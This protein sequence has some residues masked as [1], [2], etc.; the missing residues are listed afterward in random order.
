MNQK[1]YS[2][3]WLLADAV[4]LGLVV[5][6]AIILILQPETKAAPPPAHLSSFPA[7]PWLQSP[8]DLQISKDGP[9]HVTVLDTLT[10]TI[11]ITN[12]AGQTLQNVVI[13]DTYTTKVFPAQGNI[14]PYLALYNGNYVA[15]GI[16]VQ[17]FTYTVDT[18]LQRGA[19]YWYLAN[20]AP[21][22]SG[23]IVFTMGI[24]SSLQPR[25]RDPAMGPSDLE[26]S[27]AITT[28]TS[29]VPVDTNPYDN[30]VVSS[31]VGPVLKLEKSLQTETG[32]TNEERIGRLVTYTIRV[33]NLSTSVREDSWP[34][35][36]L[37]VAEQLPA[38]LDFI[39]TWAAVSGVTMEY[40]PTLR[41]IT[42]TYPPDF[43]L[44]PGDVT[45]VT[46]TTR[47]SLTAPT[48]QTIKNDKS[49]CWAISAEMSSPVQ[50]INDLNLKVLSPQDKSAETASPPTAVDQS[51]PNRPV[52]YTVYL[53][54]PL[55]TVLTDVTVIDQLPKTFSFQQMINGPQPTS[56]L[57]NIVRWE[58][59]TI[60][61]NEVISFTF[62]VWIDA[63]TPVEDNCNNKDYPN[64]MTVTAPALPVP[65]VNKYM[66][67]VRVIPQLRV[68]KSVFPSNQV[69]GSVVTY[70]IS[71]KNEGDTTIS[72]LILTDTLPTDFRFH[73]MA[74]SPPG[75]PHIVS[76]TPNVIWWDSFPPLAPG[77]QLDFSFRATVDGTPMN[78]YQNEVFGY[79][80]DTSVCHLNKAGV[81]VE[82]P[83]VYEKTASPDSVV[84]GESF[85]YTVRF[86]NISSV[87]SYAIDRFEDNLPSGFLANGMPNYIYPISPSF[88]L[89]PNGSNEWEHSF[90][91]VVRGEGTNTTWC[92]NLAREDKRSV[93]QEREKFGVHTVDPD[94]LWLNRDKMA[95]VY[96]LP[97]VSLM[98]LAQPN[99]VGRSSVLTV[100]L[101]LTNNLRVANA[102]PV[103]V[104]ALTYKLPRGALTF[105]GPV[106]G[107]PNPDISSDSNYDYYTW[108]NLT[109]PAQG[110]QRLDI[111]FRAPL[112]TANYATYA[113]ALPQTLSICI[114]KYR[115]DIQVVNGVELSKEPTPNTIG[116]FGIVE[117][118]IEATNLTGGPVSGLRITDTLPEGFQYIRTTSGPE[119]IS[120]SPLVWEI[121][122][123]GPV[124]SGL[125]RATIKFLARSY[126][127][128]GK[129][130]NW[131]DGVSASTYITRINGYE[132]KVALMVV[133]GIG[134]YK[135]A[136]PTTVVTGQTV[137]YTITLYNG[138]ETNIRNIR[139]TD[140]LPSGFT[141]QGM[142]YGT[143]PIQI[144][145][146]VWTASSLNKGDSL[147]LA[148]RA[149]VG[150]QVP[151]GYYYNRVSGYAEKAVSP[152]DPVLV[153]DTGDTA[154][155]HVRGLP[156]V[157]RGKAVT[158][159]NVMAGEQVTYTLFLYNEGE[160]MH[161]VRLTD[162]LPPSVT[163][164][165][166][167]GSPA[168]VMTSPLVWDN[169]QVEAGTTV[170]LQFLA[171]VDHLAHSGTYYNRLDAVVDGR[172][173]PPLPQL[174]PLEVTEI[175]RLDVRVSIDDGRLLVNEGDS[176]TYTVTVTNSNGVNVP[177]EDTVI[178]VTLQPSQ[179][180][181]VTGTG[182]T[183][184]SPGVWEY[185]VGVVAA[186]GVFSVPLY[187]ELGTGIP[188][189]VMTISATA[190]VGYRTAV[191][192]IEENRANNRA[193]D[194]DILRGPDL[195]V[196]DL[197]WKPTQPVAG[198]PITF[199]ATIRNQGPEGAFQ[200]WDGSSDHWLFIVELYAKGRD[201]TPAD[202]P[203]DVFDHRGG[204]C[205]DASCTQTRYE[206]LAWPAGLNAGAERTLVFRNIYL[207]VDTYRIYVQADV[208]WPGS[209]PWGQPFGMIREAIENNNIYDAGT[210]EI[211]H[212]C[213]FLPLVLRNR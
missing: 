25:F 16:T 122:Y 181:T 178:T 208:S 6:I 87:R 55:Q 157:E 100:T 141:Y 180:L 65:Y 128:L 63:Q 3:Q 156:T 102:A 197:R 207:P 114:P 116:P 173:L 43:T 69:P 148:F 31:I 174:A 137:V 115:L 94:R 71:L 106:G 113:E 42:W 177:I 23:R 2:R 92:D 121:P 188:P 167:L 82:S 84:Q 68:N 209:A 38:G 22:A 154:P 27:V 166:V 24:S 196:T 143:P 1:R 182:W 88:G 169:I 15:Q 109:V 47:I 162:T 45:F 147:V 125:H 57:T 145:P 67:T 140:T 61:A 76:D 159:A 49:R 14:M 85:T 206:S 41:I 10:Y 129:Q 201:F 151:T 200:R 97:H 176:L 30:I 80:P 163:F 9:D 59:L 17:G 62:R 101:Y 194:I 13:T 60:P 81:R 111:Q 46:F 172:V 210:V 170:T 179:Y 40:T 75:A 120:L 183:E 66:A 70:T 199:Y 189:D 33:E 37:K 58:G 51:F 26:N 79:T 127:L 135:V 204:Y 192:T 98:A 50:C 32:R 150:E 138:S 36:G 104:T 103:T 18:V 158:P 136:E 7:A 175:P 56:I 91:V 168:P 99:P 89:A 124:N 11:R 186:G 90:N 149:Q 187:I 86:R 203:V 21:G 112:T 123:L 212:Y 205:A 54:N 195:V 133:S 52:T 19:I 95:S 184:V 96:V 144:D 131:I 107:T 5:T 155:V 165:T 185:P 213:V 105:L 193:E 93:Y 34:A 78:T 29:G 198:R 191:T 152:Y 64:V 171:E 119:P 130:Y 126:I 12:T 4:F 108:R 211:K 118:K 20:L 44:N 83:I 160:E 164:V 146:L 139:I 190:E 73:S 48:G 77:S 53:Y 161:T 72:G 132:N 117:Y 202:P 153:P 134:L 35:T 142:R 74:S 110:S 8:N 28:S 39:Q